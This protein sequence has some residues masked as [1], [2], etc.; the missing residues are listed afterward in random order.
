VLSGRPWEIAEKPRDI[1]KVLPNLKGTNM[2]RKYSSAHILISAVVAFC[3]ML[4]AGRL[5]GQM[6]GTVETS[7]A[8]PNSYVFQLELGGAVVAEYTDCTGLGSSN[9]VNEVTEITASGIAVIHQTPGAL[10]WRD[11]TLRRTGLSGDNV[12]AWRQ[13]MV[14]GNP[15]GG[16]RDGAIVV[17]EKG[18]SEPLARW[19]FRRGW[20]ASLCLQGSTEELI[21]LH[22]GLERVGAAGTTPPIRPR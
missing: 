17:C 20:A 13:A 3:L 9:D 18:C 11:I 14:D 2:A 8:E 22:D 4:A 5:G 21:V 10:R 19:R 12:W 6:T 7:P 15:D 16:I 1:V